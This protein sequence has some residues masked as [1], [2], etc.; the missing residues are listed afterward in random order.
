MA[1]I[2]G[3]SFDCYATLGRCGRRAIGTAARRVLQISG[4]VFRQSGAP[5]KCVH[6]GNGSLKSSGQNDARASYRLCV[7]ADRT[8]SRHQR[9][10][11][12]FQL[13]DGVTA[14]CCVVFRADGAL[15]LTSGGPTGT[16]QR[17]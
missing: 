2:F 10:N 11:M 4:P 16:A 9:S 8:L 1:Y 7:S 15:L 13:L 17:L 5:R 12:Y 3:D 6:P 14:Q